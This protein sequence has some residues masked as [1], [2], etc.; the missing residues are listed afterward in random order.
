MLNANTI[1]RLIAENRDDPEML[2]FICDS[3]AIFESYHNAVLT[4]QLY[5]I[6]YGGGGIDAAEFRTKWMELDRAR[7]VNHN[8]VIDRVNALNRLAAAGKLDPVYDGEVSKEQPYRRMI[9]DAVFEYID[10]II[11][12]RS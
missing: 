12:N 5:R 3:I 8:A 7:T 6:V 11:K 10:R 2:E 9:A 4:D 1:N